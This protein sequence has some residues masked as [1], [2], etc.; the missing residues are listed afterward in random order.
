VTLES[1]VKLSSAATGEPSG[2]ALVLLPGPTDSWRSYEPVL[3]CLPASIRAIAVSQRGHGDSDKPPSGY[4]VEEDFAAEVELLLDALGIERAV[5]AGHS[6]SAW[7]PAELLSTIPSVCR[8]WCWKRL[9]RPCAG[10]LA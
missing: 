2:P 6:G 4:R 3:Q 10:T 8:D 9:P 5:L 7:P 1:G